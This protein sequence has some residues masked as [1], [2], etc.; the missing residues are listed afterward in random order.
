MPIKAGGLPLRIL[1]IVAAWAGIVCGV[2]IEAAAQPDRRFY[3]GAAL[4]GSG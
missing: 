4:V 3:A 2:P 1:G